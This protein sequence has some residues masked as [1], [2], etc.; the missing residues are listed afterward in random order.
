[1][2]S[3]E[4]QRLFLRPF[5]AGDEKDLFEYLKKPEVHCFY[6]MKVETLEQA[7]EEVMARAKDEYWLAIE[8]KET[9][10]VIGELFGHPE[11]TDPTSSVMDTFSPCWMLNPAFKGKGYGYEACY[12]YIDSLFKNEGIRRVYMYTEDYNLACQKL[13]EK[14]GA[15]QE[16][17]FREFVSFINDENGNPVYEN[18]YQY[19]I[20]KREWK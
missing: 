19:A 10:K 2:K 9:G 18:T 14:L 6:D 15:R 13:C 17:L 1:M 5:K 7:A 11:G 20:L 12:A 4:T 16:G 3:I 8:L